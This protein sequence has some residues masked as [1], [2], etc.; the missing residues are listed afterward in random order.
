M[1]AAVVVAAA[2]T[3]EVMLDDHGFYVRCFEDGCGYVSERTHSKSTARLM[4][5]AH[6]SAETACKWCGLA[7]EYS[8]TYGGYRVANAGGPATFCHPSPVGAHSLREAR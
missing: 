8:E 4:A 1:S 7:V 3:C 6:D 2:G 5:A